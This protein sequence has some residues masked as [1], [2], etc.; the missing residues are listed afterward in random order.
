MDSQG[1]VRTFS[2]ASAPYENELLAPTRMR[3]GGWV[4][5]DSIQRCYLPLLESHPDLR[6]KKEFHDSFTSILM[7]HVLKIRAD[8]GSFDGPYTELFAAAKKLFRQFLAE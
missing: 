1:A 5:R 4:G 3:N 7:F 8:P 2:I 6:I